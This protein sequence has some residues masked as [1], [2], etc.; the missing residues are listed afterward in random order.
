M[1]KAP[2]RPKAH[3]NYALVLSAKKERDKALDELRIAGDL[4]PQDADIHY[5][6]GV[7]HLRQGHLDEA[8][9]EFQEALK[10]KGDHADARHNLT[11]LE[12][13]DK[14]YGGERV[15]AGVR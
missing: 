14:R 2:S 1:A 6:A 7:I 10:R 11:L 13:L 3:Y 8:K 9:K 12:D 5:L 15:G 4:D